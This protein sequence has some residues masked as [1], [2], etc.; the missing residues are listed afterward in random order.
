MLWLV[1]RCIQGASLAMPDRDDS[2]TGQMG[3]I[4]SKNRGVLMRW[5]DESLQ[6]EGVAGAGRVGN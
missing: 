4:S 5:R 2:S 6:K 3:C 1:C